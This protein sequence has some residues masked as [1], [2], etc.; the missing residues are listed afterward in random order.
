MSA[1]MP[2]T[3][4][5]LLQLL[6]AGILEDVDVELALALTQ[7]V[8]S[9]D[10]NLRLAVALVCKAPRD[11]HT[12][13]ALHDTA[14][15]RFASDEQRALLPSSLSWP[16][17]DEL[18]MSLAS[19]PLLT[20]DKCEGVAPLLL[21]DDQLYLQRFDVLEALL[22][23]S[24]RT[25][26]QRARTELNADDEARLLTLFPESAAESEAM[27]ERTSSA[28]STQRSAAAVAITSPL[29]VITGGPGTGKTTTVLRV[30][31][32]LLARTP[33]DQLPDILL[34]APTGKA[35][36]RLTESIAQGIARLPVGVLDADRL[37]AIPARAQTIH[38]ALG[39]SPDRP[40]RPRHHAGNRLPAD[41][42]I[43]DETSMVDL[44]LM[45]RLFDAV[46]P[47]ARLLLLGDA[48]QLASVDAG[49]VLRDLVETPAL[50]RSTA[51][52]T[53]SRRFS[54]ASALGKL[55][56]ALRG[57]E[58]RAVE[59]ALEA[60]GA[61]ADVI[62][63][64]SVLSTS[65][66][67]RVPQHVLGAVRAHVGRMR[68]APTPEAALAELGRFRLLTAL[69]RS[70]IGADAINAF[71]VNEM[72]DELAPGAPVLIVE[73]AP[74]DGLANGDLGVVWQESDGR[75]SVLFSGADGPRA[76]PVRR[77]PAREPAFAMT[78]HKA[79]GSEFDKVMV[80]LPPPPSPILTRE[81]L[82]TA[83]SRARTQV[84]IVGPRAAIAAAHGTRVRRATG[85]RARLELQTM[86]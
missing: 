77:L 42:V 16:T 60:N 49:A 25:R 41:I 36:S 67:E 40:H 21:R 48:D 86:L 75:R 10:A 38:R 24:V 58:W 3:D 50:E 70:P 65:S 19:S 43:V 52:L 31:A 28:G 23:R 39:V 32:A 73:N 64:V 30:L 44:P 74:D 79:Q 20:P 59:H 46:R 81:L 9:D 29:A 84:T 62:A 35:A 26:L 8:D 34:L 5:R 85:L 13:L 22:A 27:R 33:S 80:L 12:C 15:E 68:E 63:P 54:D 76:I 37:A 78:V 53:Y 69:R 56:I 72:G 18:R 6:A 66:S 71:F 14:L 61:A 82:Y 7:L 47:D 83:V 4:T 51:M 57:E 55:V 11:G 2:A 17:P 45:A 1:V